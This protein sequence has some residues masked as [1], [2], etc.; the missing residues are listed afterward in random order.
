[1]PPNTFSTRAGTR[2]NAVVFLRGLRGLRAK[3]AKLPSRTPA[4]K[5]SWRRWLAP[6]PPR[7]A[8]HGGALRL[9]P[10]RWAS[11]LPCSVR[12]SPSPACPVSDSLLVRAVP[13]FC[14]GRSALSSPS[15]PSLFPFFSLKALRPRAVS[16][17]SLNPGPLGGI[18]GSFSNSR[19]RGVH[20]GVSLA[21]AKRQPCSCLRDPVFRLDLSWSP[22]R[23]LLGAPFQPSQGPSLPAAW[24]PFNRGCEPRDQTRTKKLEAPWISDPRGL[25]SVNSERK[26][27]RR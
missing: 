13:S 18:T 23:H 8:G 15:C 26:R 1:M 17:A 24:V 19:E 10:G 5:V 14:L 2:Q 25:C 9:L 7:G 27:W 12:L 4:P 3:A 21:R 11:G 22:P 20:P 6:G 16:H